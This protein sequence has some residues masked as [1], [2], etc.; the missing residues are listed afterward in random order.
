M[1][2]LPKRIRE[3]L[4]VD[5]HSATLGANLVRSLVGRMRDEWSDGAATAAVMADAMMSSAADSVAAGTNPARLSAELATF[6]ETV[7]SALRHSAVDVEFKE[8]VAAVVRTATADAT[9]NEVFRSRC[10]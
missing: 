2:D 8:Q 5:G 4:P 6:A 9:L 1:Y 10:C 7:T 3:G